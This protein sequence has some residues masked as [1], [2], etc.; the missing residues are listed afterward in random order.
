MLWLVSAIATDIYRN[1]EMYDMLRGCFAIPFMGVMLVCGFA[2]LH[3]DLMRLRWVVLGTFLS[4]LVAIFIFK[5]QVLYAMADKYDF[6]IEDIVSFKTYYAQ[7]LRHG[8][9]LIAAFLYNNMPLLVVLIQLAMGGFYLFSG[10][11]SIF[12][13]FVVC[14]LASYAGAFAFNSLRFMQRNLVISFIGIS[15]II[16]GAKNI[17]KYAT[18]EGWL[19]DQE[20][21]KY[22]EQSRSK[23]GL[24]AGRSEFIG[25]L[26]AIKDSPVLGHGSWPVDY[27]MYRRRIMVW[28]GDGEAVDIYDANLQRTGRLGAIPSHSHIWQGW[29]WHGFFGGLFWVMI[30]FWVVKYLLKGI[31]LL[32]PLLAY[33]LIIMV[34][35]IWGLLFSP[36]NNRS[37]WGILLATVAVTLREVERREASKRAGNAINVDAPWDGRF[38]R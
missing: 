34:S 23:I 13:V 35:A 31:H 17:Y 9:C 11:R 28:L 22:E 12:L 25:A 14:S 27:K 8:G 18:V 7:V 30:L 36:F 5:P 29:V 19:G 1:V 33:N 24:L 10:S 15:I 21:I 3:D 16:S 26:A 4:S 20:L 6:A 37:G 2:L 38:R 32:R